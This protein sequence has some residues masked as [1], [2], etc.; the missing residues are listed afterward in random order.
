MIAHDATSFQPP[1]ISTQFQARAPS[2]AADERRQA[3][4]SLE[5]GPV[6]AEG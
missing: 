1:A 6:L 5:G 4:R 3:W 2:D